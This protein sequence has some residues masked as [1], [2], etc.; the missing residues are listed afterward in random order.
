MI[1]AVCSAACASPGTA[2]GT[3]IVVLL[4]VV[5][6]HGEELAFLPTVRGCSDVCMQ[7]VG[8]ERGWGARAVQGDGLDSTNWRSHSVLRAEKQ[9]G[10]HRVHA[11]VPFTASSQV[12]APGPRRTDAGA[13]PRESF[14]GRLAYTL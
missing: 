13:S 1:P 3:L 7:V 12:W 11:T 4:G 8:E 9:Q 2:A 5:R 14:Q 10:G 6:L